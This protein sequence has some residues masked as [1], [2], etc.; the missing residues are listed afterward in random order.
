MKKP[1]ERYRDSIR[2]KA[3]G[4]T[5]PVIN[6]RNT[7]RQIRAAYG[8]TQSDILEP[9]PVYLANSTNEGLR[10]LGTNQTA[11]ARVGTVADHYAIEEIRI[12]SQTPTEAMITANAASKAFFLFRPVPQRAVLATN[13]QFGRR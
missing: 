12:Q 8:S 2:V 7:T 4:A 1:A 10:V 6:Q 3:V 5:T 13:A 11:R 9:E